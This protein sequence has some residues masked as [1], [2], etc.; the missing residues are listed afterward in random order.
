MAGQY[1]Q[2]VVCSSQ[3][4]AAAADGNR[5][6]AGR[7]IGIDDTEQLASLLIG[8]AYELVRRYRAGIAG[9]AGLARFPRN[10]FQWPR[11]AIKMA[12]VW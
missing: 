1:T 10:L 11:I 8:R 6:R 9:A 3:P 12:G 5:V 4:R 2:S 7:I